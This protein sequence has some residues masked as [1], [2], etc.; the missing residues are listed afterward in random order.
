MTT[1]THSEKLRVQAIAKKKENDNHRRLNKMKRVHLDYG[2]YLLRCD[3]PKKKVASASEQ[4]CEL[5]FRWGN[6]VW[7]ASVVEKNES[8]TTITCDRHNDDE[9]YN[10]K[11]HRHKKGKTRS[12]T[13][14]TRTYTCRATQKNTHIQKGTIKIIV[15]KTKNNGKSS[16][17][18]ICVCATKYN[19]YFSFAR[20]IFLSFFCSAFIYFVSF[21]IPLFFVCVRAL[22]SLAFVCAFPMIFNSLF[23]FPLLGDAPDVCIF[24][25]ARFS[26]IWT[27]VLHLREKYFEPF[28]FL[29]CSFIL[30]LVQ[31]FEWRS[32]LDA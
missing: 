22:Y 3:E 25:L 4:M 31:G 29:F 17:W 11:K 20:W 6:R 2:A 5:F 28:C 7:E 13:T 9:K 18:Y 8:G 15:I 30:I 10:S 27:S 21:C 1:S 32:V 19:I 12:K 26:C 24:D 16:Q 14:S 23:S